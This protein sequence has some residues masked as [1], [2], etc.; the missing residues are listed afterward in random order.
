MHLFDNRNHR[1]WKNANVAVNF[2]W[3][4]YN[5]LFDKRI[6]VFAIHR[7]NLKKWNFLMGKIIKNCLD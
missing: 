1:A 7:F 2:S 3:K 4:V 6:F 5:L